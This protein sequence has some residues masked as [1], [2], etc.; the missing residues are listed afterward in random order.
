MI[1]NNPYQGYLE[2]C[3]TSGYVPVITPPNDGGASTLDSSNGNDH[4]VEHKDQWKP[5]MSEHEAMYTVFGI[6]AFVMI[7]VLTFIIMVKLK[8]RR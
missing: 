5:G 2:R 6:I 4:T 8:R 1:I 3:I 7:I